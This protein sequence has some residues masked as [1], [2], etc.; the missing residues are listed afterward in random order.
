MQ[1]MCAFSRFHDMVMTGARYG[2]ALYY[3]LSNTCQA[4]V[5]YD[6]ELRAMT[7]EHDW[8]TKHPIDRQA[9]SGRRRQKAIEFQRHSVIQLSTLVISNQSC[10]ISDT[11]LCVMAHPSR[12]PQRPFDTLGSLD[13]LGSR[14]EGGHG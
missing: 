3:I 4:F 9:E 11:Q 2:N 1:N 7:L 6:T 14:H 10:K 8:S 12:Y 5:L 13:S